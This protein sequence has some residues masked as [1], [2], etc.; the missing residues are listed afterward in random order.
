MAQEEG[1][2]LPDKFHTLPGMVY[3][4]FHVLADVGEFSGGNLVKTVSTDCLRVDAMTI[5]KRRRTR[6]LV[7]NKTPEQQSTVLTG[8]GT[9][10]VTIRRLNEQ[11]FAQAT[12]DVATFRDQECSSEPVSGGKIDISLLPYEVATL[13]F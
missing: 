7:I 11:T 1:S 2:P 9:R 10:S 5:S 6:I 12:A 4:V 13:D 8:L 3:P